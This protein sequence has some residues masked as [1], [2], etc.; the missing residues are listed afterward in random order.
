MHILAFAIKG[1]HLKKCMQNVTI[2][3]KLGNISW[4]FPLLFAPN[5]PYPMILGCNFLNKTKFIIDFKSK[6][7]F[8]L[9]H[10]PSPPPIYVIF[11]LHLR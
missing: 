5:I 10:P 9:C 3:I 6:S 8:P 7:H 2:H 1:K 4:D 11:H